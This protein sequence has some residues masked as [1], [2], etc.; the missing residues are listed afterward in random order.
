MNSWNNRDAPKRPAGSNSG[1]REAGHIRISI[2]DLAVFLFLSFIDFKADRLTMKGAPTRFASGTLRSHT[3]TG[4][5]NTHTQKKQHRSHNLLR[6]NIPQQRGLLGM[7]RRSQT[8]VFL[9]Q[10]IIFR[11]KVSFQLPFD[12]NKKTH[13]TRTEYPMKVKNIRSK[14]SIRSFQF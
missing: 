10:G 11:T 6:T 5:K 12:W 4:E 2:A 8:Q 13:L 7:Q 3:A 9:I 1:Y 14:N